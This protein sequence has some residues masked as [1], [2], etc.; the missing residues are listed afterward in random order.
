MIEHPVDNHPSTATF[1]GNVLVEKSVLPETRLGVNCAT[2][3]ALEYIVTPIL[4]YK[5]S[6]LVRLAYR[7]Q[8]AIFHQ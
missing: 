2:L 3:L 1:V 7:S 5:T 4:F 8:R 6:S